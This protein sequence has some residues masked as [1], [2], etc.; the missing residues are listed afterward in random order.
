VPSMMMIM[1]LRIWVA[2]IIESSRGMGRWSVR[3]AAY[4]ITDA[5]PLHPGQRPTER[6]APSQ[7]S[8]ARESRTT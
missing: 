7:E 8:K 1:P 3:Q 2:S 6:R 5:A 4:F